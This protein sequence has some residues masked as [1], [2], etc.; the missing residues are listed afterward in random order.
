MSDQISR[1]ELIRNASLTAGLSAMGGGVWSSKAVA[2]SKSPNEKLNIGCIGVGGQG[3]SDVGNVSSENIVAI[4]DVDS[5]RAAANFERYS[6]ALKFQDY[7][8]LIEH[9]S[10]DAVTVSI[11]DHHHAFAT[12]AALHLGKHVYCQKPLTHTVYEARYITRLAA[13][14]KVATQMGTQGHAFPE[15]SRLV[16]LIQSGA[17]GK[18][19]QVYVWTDRPTGWW[20]QGVT[21]PAS[22]MDI[23]STLNWDQWLGPALDRPYNKAYL[24][25]VWRG[26]WDFGTGSLG[27]M[28]CHLMDPVFWALKLGFPTSVEADAEGATKDSPPKAATIHYDFPARGD[29]P[30]VRVTW[31]D[32]NRRFPAELL[33]GE[34][35]PQIDNG[36][37]FIGDKG[38]L[39][40]NHGS[41]PILLPRAKFANYKGPEPY[42][43]RS[44]GHHIEWIEACKTGSPTGS[45]FGYAGPMTESILLGNVAIRVGHKINYDAKNMKV[46]DDPE[47]N[48]LLYPAIRKGWKL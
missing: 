27:D 17:I 19:T 46:I 48:A 37:L 38:K 15:Y 39:I 11:P 34:Q 4:C 20:P 45:H 5:A 42:L 7:R 1:R 36:S 18:V 33:E 40:V 13:K 28:A 31:T 21:K 8:S 25:F 3:A 2:Q 9:K 29:L 12:A 35:I 43:K 24:P 22:G 26:W 44:P 14:T 32:A 6:K 41:A 16:E 10:V 47:A 30:A 23:P